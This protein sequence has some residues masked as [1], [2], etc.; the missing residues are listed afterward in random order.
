ML[1]IYVKRTKYVP[2]YLWKFLLPLLIFFLYFVFC[3][4]NVLI[5]TGSLRKIQKIFQTNTETEFLL[6]KSS[7]PN[8]SHFWLVTIFV[9]FLAKKLALILLYFSEDSFLRNLLYM[10]DL[11][12][13]VSF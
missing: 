9:P 3:P 2:F 10:C 5:S 7:T 13:L 12:I 6:Y 1:L 11:D 8:I 4:R